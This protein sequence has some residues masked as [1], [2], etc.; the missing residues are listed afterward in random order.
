MGSLTAR[1][2]LV[3]GSRVLTTFCLSTYVCNCLNYS[4][5]DHAGRGPS[6]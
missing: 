3:A 1:V 2:R 4:H 5:V 6:H